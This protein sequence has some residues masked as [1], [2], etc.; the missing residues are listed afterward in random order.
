MHILKTRSAERPMEEERAGQRADRSVVALLLAIKLLLLPF[1][2]I[3]YTVLQN[4]TLGGLYGW[5]S[6]WNQWDSQHYQDV[7]QYGYVTAGD[8]G[9]WIVFFPLFP[10]LV[11]LFAILFRDYL[12]SAFVVSTLSSIAVVLLLRRLAQL[13][14]DRAVAI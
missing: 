14:V 2:G 1:G 11:R 12:L 5:L 6:V 3:A 8:Q 9:P 13:D 10:W 4:K 7:A